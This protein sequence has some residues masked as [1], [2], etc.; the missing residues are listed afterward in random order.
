MA[1]MEIIQVVRML[2]LY[3]FMEVPQ[4]VLETASS[5][6]ETVCMIQLIILFVTMLHIM[7]F[8]IFVSMQVP[9]QTMIPLQVI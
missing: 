9:Y 1:T 7:M 4:M 5:S 6:E 8:T 2:R 3:H